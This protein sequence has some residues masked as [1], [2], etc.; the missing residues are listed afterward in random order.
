MKK[1]LLIAAVL[2][3]PFYLWASNHRYT[4]RSIPIDMQQHLISLG[5]NVGH[6]APLGN[7]VHDIVWAPG[8]ETKDPTAAIASYTYSA[9]LKTAIEAL[10]VKLRA[11]TINPTEK[12]D[13]LDKM[14]QEMG[15]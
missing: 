2:S 1:I 6:V 9:P 13:L 15:Y 5:F 8:G 11:G 14:L 10:A 12:D 7:D 4:K 3:L